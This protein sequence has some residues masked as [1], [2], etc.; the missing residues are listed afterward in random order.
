MTDKSNN[1]SLSDLLA[2]ASGAQAAYD[3]ETAVSLFSQALETGDLP[4]TDE[5][6]LRNG[7]AACQNSLAAFET[8]LIDL[9]AMFDLAQTLGD[10]SKQVDVLARW[11]VAKNN[12]GENETAKQ[13]AQKALEIA[14]EV[15]DPKLKADSLVALAQSMS[16]TDAHTLVQQHLE[17][18]IDLYR[19]IDDPANEGMTLANL[20]YSMHQD[21]DF[22]RG[23][24]I[25]ENGLKLA[26]KSG[27]NYAQV[28]T[29]IVRALLCTDAAE[30]L[31]YDEEAL[32]INR[33]LGN[34]RAQSVL[35][36]NM[37]FLLWSLGLYGRA[38]E[39]IN[40]AI[41]LAGQMNSEP[42]AAYA[43]E[44]VGRCYLG[45]RM[46]DEAES[47]FS[48]ATRLSRKIGDIFNEGASTTGLGEIALAR[49]QPEQAIEHIQTSLNLQQNLNSSPTH[50]LALMGA[51]YL[52]LGNA[53]DAREYTGRAT[54]MLAAGHFSS[55][56]PAH[57]G[58]WWHYQALNGIRPAASPSEEA[59]NAL[60]NACRQMLD[61]ITTL[62]DEGLRRNYLN[63][64]PVN[65]DIT[66]E[67][68]NRAKQRGISL[69]PFTEHEADAANLQDQF[70][71]IVDIGARLTAHRDPSNLANFVIEEFVELSGV[72]R[73][74]L[75]L[76]DE[77]GTVEITASFSPQDAQVLAEPLLESMR[78]NRQPA[79][80]H[81]VG[82][83]PE[84]AV[85]ESH[86]RTLIALPLVSQ[87]RF[88]GLLYGDMRQI[89][90]RF[91]EADLDLF[92]LLANQAAAALENAH[93]TQSLEQKVAQ[94]TAELEAANDRLE[95]RNAELAVINGVQQGLVAQVDIQAIYDLVGDQIHD[96]F[97]AQSVIIVTLDQES[98]L[99]SF[100]YLLEKEQRFY[101]EPSA[102]P[103]ILR[104]IRSRQPL[105]VNTEAEFNELGLRTIEG[106]EP[107]RSGLFVPLI[108]GKTVIGGISL[109]NLDR[110]YAFS[111]ADLR[112]LTTLANSMSI[113]LENA[114]LFDET[115]RLLDE[116]QQRNAELAIINSVQAG[117]AAQMDIQAIY[118]LVGQKIG[119]VFP[120]ADVAIGFIDSETNLVNAPY[121]VEHGKR[122]DIDPFPL[123]ETGFLAQL[124]RTKKPILVNEDMA[125]ATE[126][127]G[128]S[129]IQDTDL[130][131]SALYVPLVVAGETKGDILLQ[132]M[133]HEFAFND[134]DVRL[135]TT[136]ANSMSIALE[137][138]RLF[139]ETNRLLKETEQRNAELAIINSV[140]EAMASQLDV[141]TITRLV[142]DKVCDIFL[143]EAILITLYDR[144]ANLLHFPYG[145][146]RGF[147][148]VESIPFGEG[149]ISQIIEDRRPLRYGTHD[150]GTAMGAIKVKVTSDDTSSEPKTESYIG[151][152]I[153]IG[154]AVMG[155]ISV[156][157]Y[158]K[159]A[160][161]EDDVRLL[162][163]LATNMGVAI[164]NGRLFQEIQH[165]AREMSAVAEVGRDISATL[166][167]PTVLE[168][169]A[170]HARDLLEVSD[171]AVFLPDDTG[172]LMRGYI[173]LGP[174]AEQVKATTVQ[175]GRGILGDIW[176]H[177]E[178][179]V[180]NNT[181]T[182]PRAITI[183]GTDTQEDERM[184]A[185]PLLAGTNVAGLMAVWRTGELFDDDDLRFLDGLARQAA[186]AIENARLFTEAEAAR[187]IAEEANESK[188]AFLANVSHELRTPLTSILGFARIVQKRLDDRIFPLISD[189]EDRAQRAMNQIEGNLEIIMAEGE[190]LTTLINN[191][192]DLEKIEAGK[193]DWHMEPVI[194][195]D[196]VDQGLAATMALVEQ[197]GLSLV[198]E[199]PEDLPTITGDRD[200]LVQVM[201]NLISNAVKFT[202]TGTITCRAK[203]G[204]GV[205]VTS[206][207]DT[208]TGIAE[209]D[210]P[211]VFEKFKQVGDTL[212]D[213]P[214]GTGLGLPICR[215]IID[216]HG[217]QIWLDSRIGEGSTFYFTL[218]LAVHTVPTGIK[219]MAFDE[220]LAQLK[221]RISDVAV[222]S[223]GDGN[224][225]LVVD[226][227]PHIRELLR[228]ELSTE[229]YQVFEAGDGR[230]A[231]AQVKAIQPDLVIL[232]VF[233]PELSGFDVAAVIKNDPETMGLPIVV[234][235]VLEDKE[236]GYR[237]GVDRYLTKP[238]DLTA[239]LKEVE[240][241]LAQG[242]S[243]RKVMVIDENATT[244]QTLSA[245]LQA[246][247]YEVTAVTS[248][249][250]GI[251]RAMD[252]QPDMIIV[253]SIVSQEYNMVQA[254]RFEKGLENV[255]FLLFQ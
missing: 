117:L 224:T 167:L 121:V 174:I 43:L 146:D 144:E 135:L 119:D 122:L 251:N 25:A 15:A 42:L 16:G 196:V 96:I 172:E 95:Q 234:V 89:F 26:R 102:N 99:I 203:Q 199:L 108:V 191:V 154:D 202:D 213:K 141:Q 115:N 120:R 185:A 132:D 55:E 103:N 76:L 182:D 49:N 229:G 124:V 211:T 28:R 10:Q 106:T 243:K 90:G 147:V 86:Q 176:L 210:L 59:L 157:S 233:M 24:I 58:Y 133:E 217:G 9:E 60:D 206:I 140:G 200:K 88:L 114:R 62:S 36:N 41:A 51:A 215:E 111:D 164:E 142:G 2:A 71:R 235:S 109:Q 5:F 40:N 131:K 173:A 247:G 110:E 254:I 100:R 236:R 186:I 179:E 22:E 148:E 242:P 92:A 116:T 94:R 222:G 69:A 143:A 194:M 204:D 79:V 165:R 91:T 178:A 197:K 160:Y 61:G 31:K 193:M 123:G 73:A 27:S 156:Q 78:L 149:L 169:I 212:T 244:V 221:Y 181:G 54:E 190:R 252:E 82:D 166:D 50:E 250:D 125:R 253:S 158:E 77:A 188:S 129:T 162:S 134:S 128:S 153:I 171:T 8:E 245:A 228:Q 75:L 198:K 249:A 205:I 32:E 238:I 209:E 63:K 80:L 47:A 231:L 241:L 101:P 72:E 195:A 33:Q 151:V 98:D 218:P 6:T 4:A 38:Q 21:G 136:L 30:A 112:L 207:S 3:Y 85:P 208:G 65:R 17:D 145:Y 216:Y 219:T 113:A 127:I 170:R 56:Y 53:A 255:L 232:D 240:T 57:E 248:G 52:A 220:L 48:E 34:R 35:V 150:E 39:Y 159:N 130:P 223:A 184:M 192:L 175:P 83:V 237:L 139:D 74:L 104:M 163:T 161:D 152:P 226:D 19:Q 18:A 12:L 14:G 20:A 201:I 81:D 168:R 105:K 7:R 246:Q 70:K 189:D 239:L 177:Q 126:E 93:W 118:E 230:E 68:A 107:S 67:W 137:N 29:L 66:L 44:G 180:I 87:G 84:D 37:G 227:D 45:L 187:A 13:L 23:A 11:S 138:A 225:V 46:L 183:A 155:A 214:K 1:R 64:V 97:D